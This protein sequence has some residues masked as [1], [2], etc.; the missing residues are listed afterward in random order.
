MRRWSRQALRAWS[1]VL[2]S[3]LLARRWG[4]RLVVEVGLVALVIGTIALAT[5]T[6]GPARATATRPTKQEIAQKILHSRAG[7]R[8][9]PGARI[10]LE[11][12]ARGDHRAAVDSTGISF[13][14]A[15]GRSGGH[16]PG[17]PGALANVRVNNPGEDTHQPDQTTQSET[18]IAVS[19][20]NVVVGFNDSQA[21]LLFFTPGTDL[22]GLAVSHNGGLTFSDLGN[23]PNATPTINLGD[24]WLASD[25]SGA[26]YYANLVDDP[27]QGALFVGVSRSTDGG[28][29]FSAPVEIPPPA[30]VSTFFYSA[31]KDA[32]TAGSGVGNLYTVWDDFTETF[33]PNTGL[34]QVLSGLPVA[35]STDGGSSWSTVY[36]DQVP[37]FDS[38]DPCSFH[39]YIGAQPIIGP[40]GTVYDAALRFDVNDPTCSGAPETE[41]EYIFA[42]HDGGA[43][44]PQKVKIADVTSSTQGFGAFVLGAGQF[45]RNLEFPTLAFLG[46]T[47]Y[48]TWNDGGDGSGHSHI[49]LASSTDGGA[50]WSTSFVT[51]GNNDEA[52]PSISA[53][54]SGLHILYYELS[55][56]SGGASVLDTIVADSTNGSSFTTTRVT[57][58]S[59][60]GV[61]NIPN[62]DPIIAAAYMG[63]YIS[64]VSS[65]GHQYFAW[66]DNRDVVTNFLWPNGR[67]DPDVFFA[68]R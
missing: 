26:F 6:S 12:L 56:A 45:M 54:A 58:Q 1:R 24:P 64:N 37:I 62:F 3:S 31:D 47:L 9:G 10:A 25:S 21:T 30:G 57:T 23:L 46:N 35:H 52:Q 40:D 42:S 8:L 11:A 43:T 7:P 16:A 2:S 48:A 20:K 32:M 50:T 53:D 39:Q 29:T 28:Q 17:G 33:D 34:F 65:G 13:S 22:S 61:F 4:L 27:F 63:D 14:K 67:H 60:P 44:F 15:K 18:T 36:A 66:G 59:F 68:V 19:G 49:R 51:S 5:S 38:N 41:S 55:P